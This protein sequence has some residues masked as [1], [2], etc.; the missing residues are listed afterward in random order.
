MKNTIKQLK[1]YL[2]NHNIKPS[3]I[4]LK[5]LEYLLNNRIHPTADDIYKN[6]LPQIPTL[7]K[8]SIY[9]TMELFANNGVVKI[10]SFDGK[11]AHYDVNTELH[12]HFKCRRCGI[13]Y[14]FNVPFDIPIPNELKEFDVK[15]VDINFYGICHKCNKQRGREM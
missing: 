14:D 11:E 15:E 2:I 4:R 3:T 6:L 7:S 5:V 10:L 1:E 13:I 9:N 8:T 12:G